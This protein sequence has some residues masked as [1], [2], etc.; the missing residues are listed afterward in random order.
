MNTSDASPIY[1]DFLAAEDVNFAG[2]IGL[3]IAPGKKDGSWDR[4]LGA[5]LARLR[6]EY[7]CGVLVS[8]LEA[9]EYEM[10]EIADLFQRARALGI[11]TVHFPIEDAGAPPR[12]AM[13]GFGELVAEI[14]AVA[15]AGETVVI[16]CR[17]GLGRTGTVAAACLVARGHKAD[18]AIA[19]VRAVR[20]GAIETRAQED[21]VR[22][23]ARWI[24]A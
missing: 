2:R 6:D 10:L 5:D 23:F 22:A 21:F 14:V 13:A 17:G 11:R 18:D 4:D 19:R 12:D 9:H 15:R 1:V 24:E 3:T 20:P 8:L 16:H 7:G